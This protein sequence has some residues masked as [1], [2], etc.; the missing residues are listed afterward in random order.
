MTRPIAMTLAC[1]A[2]VLT[3]GCGESNTPS[4]DSTTP[5]GWKLDTAPDAAAK[6]ADAKASAKEG[7]TIAL[8]GRIGGR[9]EPITLASGLFV[10]VD[11]AVPACSDIPDDRC[12]TPWD[13]CCEPPESL[14][15]NSATVQLRD[16]EG[17]PI[18]LADGDLSPLDKVIVVGTVAPRP[19]AQT[20]IVHAT[21]VYVTPKE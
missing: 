21:G 20:L 12:P 6:I 8:H 18:V 14:A 10:M 4:A 9:M 16:A 1:L 5:T 13:Y 15:A 11:P 3:L 2:A 7:D 19:N 17:R